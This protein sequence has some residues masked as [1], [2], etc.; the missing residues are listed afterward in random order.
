[1]NK[2]CPICNR[3]IRFYQGVVMDYGELIHHRCLVIGLRFKKR[4][5]IYKL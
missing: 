3:K 1:M 4:E 2:I 5:R